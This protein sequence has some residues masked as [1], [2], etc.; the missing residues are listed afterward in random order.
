LTI[1]R[2]TG[3]T[4][5][6]ENPPTTAWAYDGLILATRNPDIPQFELSRF[7]WPH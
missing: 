5:V 3:M 6:A 2:D 7:D 1:L 4:I